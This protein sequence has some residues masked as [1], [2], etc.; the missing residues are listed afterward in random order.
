MPPR[1]QFIRHRVQL[2]NDIISSTTWKFCPTTSTS[3]DLITRGV[4]AKA[5]I[6]KQEDWTQG[7]TWLVRPSL[8]RPSI[9]TEEI[10]DTESAEDTTSIT[11][12]I[13]KTQENTNLLNAID[14]TRLSSLN[15]TLRITALVIRFTRKPRGKTNRQNIVTAMDKR[16]AFVVLTKYVQQIHYRE[17]IS[18]LKHEGKPRMSHVQKGVNVKTLFRFADIDEVS[19][20]R[21]HK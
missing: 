3:V 13:A 9:T 15:E 17:V 4:D 19:V 14:I 10:Q 2:I 11:I 21:F 6:S 1:Q 8:E 12:N 20:A 5:F 18:K 7:L 16:D